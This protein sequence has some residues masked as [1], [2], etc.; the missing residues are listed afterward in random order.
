M[1]YVHVMEYYEAIIVN[2]VLI[3]ARTKMNFESI[4]L[5]TKGYI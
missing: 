2:D 4:M 5:D 1:W 3:Y